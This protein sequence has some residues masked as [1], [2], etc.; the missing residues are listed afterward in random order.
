MVPQFSYPW[1][2]VAS[3]RRSLAQQPTELPDSFSW[4][5]GLSSPLG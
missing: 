1:I 3:L 2:I 4:V 5:T